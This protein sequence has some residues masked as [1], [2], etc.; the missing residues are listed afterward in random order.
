M[1]IIHSS[2]S[3]F[4]NLISKTGARAALVTPY[5]TEWLQIAALFGGDEYRE[6]WEDDKRRNRTTR[7]VTRTAYF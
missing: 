6:R 2:F 7:H 4:K 3:S 1:E 5:Q